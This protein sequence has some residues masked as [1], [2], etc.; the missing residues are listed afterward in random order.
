M[1]QKPTYEELEQRIKKLGK[2]SAERKRMEG[3]LRESE[4]LFRNIYQESPIGIEIYDPEGR[5]LHVNKACLDIFGILDPKEIKGFRLFEDPNLPDYEKERLRRGETVRYEAVF[6]FELVKKRKLY[7]TSKSGVSYLEVIFTPFGLKEDKFAAGYLVQVVD[8]TERELTK[9]AL[10]KTHDDLGKRVK[11]RTSDLERTNERLLKEI[12]ERKRMEEALRESEEKYRLLIK[13]IPSV[14]WVTSEYGETS[15]ISPNVEKIYGFSPEEI[16]ESGSSLWFGRIHPDDAGMVKESF[17]MMFAKNQKFDVEYRIQRDDGE[18][19]WLHD[20]AIMAFEKDNIRYANGVFSDITNRKCAEE[21]LREA[22]DIISRSPAVA[23]LWKNAEG[24]PVEFVSDNAEK[25]FGYTAEDFVSGSVNYAQVVH[26]D[27]LDRVLREVASYSEEKARQSFSHEPYRIVAK[28]GEVRWLDDM[29]YI[30]RDKEGRITH[31]QGIV[32][33]ISERII[34]KDER[35]RLQ[36]QLLQAQKM[37]S[38]GTLAGGIAHDFN[39]ILS[40]IMTHT[41]MALMDLPEDSPVRFSLREVFKASERARDLVKQ[42]L[43]F[44]RQTEREPVPLKMGLIIKEALKLLRSSIPTTIEI[45]QQIMTDSDAIL[46]DPTQM[47]QVIMNL[48]ANAFHAMREKGGVLE[49]SLAD[50]YV[51]P[52]SAYQFDNLRLGSYLK[53]SIRDSGQGMDPD[54]IEKIFEPYFTTKDKGVGTGLGMAVV[55]GIVQNHGGSIQVNSEIGKGTVFNVYLPKLETATIE[56]IPISESTPKGVERVLLIDDEAA[57]INAGKQMLERLGYEVIT[58][59]SSIDALEL[60]RSQPDR[61]D[62]V[63]T[64][65]TMPNMTGVELSKEVMNIRPDIPVILCTGF[66]EQINGEKASGMGIRAFI[67]KPIVMSQMAN[68]IRK[69]LDEK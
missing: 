47:H 21:A 12:E 34:A 22:F 63:I 42:I 56:Q 46:A 67:M 41:E 2:E 8:N 64:D 20:M 54:V 43:A 14:T 51:D 40:P 26:P 17:E 48:C 29:T 1:V 9:K 6:D 19:I 35:E 36:S 49:V 7:K 59:T 11:E 13:N 25:T 55:L 28:N 52:E 23:F 66:S 50:E 62:I 5:L 24:W 15:F 3:A 68:T 27:D 4:E 60:F 45:Q 37:E 33:D 44:S 30:R 38:I 53:L 18:W 10:Q 16:Y 31:Y 65:M 32:L 39:N 57:I 61:F 58:R 69:V